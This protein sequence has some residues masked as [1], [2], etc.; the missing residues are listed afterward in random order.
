MERVRTCGF[1]YIAYES[2][3]L[4]TRREDASPETFSRGLLVNFYP[5]E[6]L[7]GVCR[8]AEICVEGTLKRASHP[9][10]LDIL[11]QVTLVEPMFNQAN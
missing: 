10:D 8:H 11:D 2:N 4:F 6:P 3:S 1:L 9:V 5:V 7:A